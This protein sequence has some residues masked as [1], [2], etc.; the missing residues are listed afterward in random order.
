[1]NAIIIEKRKYVVLG[2]KEYEHLLV[3]AASKTE[4][5]RKRSLAQGKKLAYRLIDRW[6]KEK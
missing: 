6:A 3:K 2:V 5:A 4:P 1:M